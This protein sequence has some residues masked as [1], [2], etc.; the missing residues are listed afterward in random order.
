MSTLPGGQNNW[1]G[2]VPCTVPKIETNTVNIGFPDQVGSQQFCSPID[3]AIL[4]QFTMSM[5]L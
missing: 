2:T 5:S 1:A 4:S 3:M